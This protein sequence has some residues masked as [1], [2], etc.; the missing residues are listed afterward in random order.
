VCVYSFICTLF[1]DAV[2]NTDYISPVIMNNERKT[3]GKKSLWL[4]LRCNPR[5]YL[6][7]PRKNRLK[8]DYFPVSIN[9]HGGEPMRMKGIGGKVHAFCGSL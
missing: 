9:S 4:N 2:S 5:M 6:K 3:C 7:V 8:S 1:K